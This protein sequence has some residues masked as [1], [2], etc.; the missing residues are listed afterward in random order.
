MDTIYWDRLTILGIKTWD[1]KARPGIA[2]NFRAHAD[3]TGSHIYFFDSGR[4]PLYPAFL[5]T[6]T[7]TIASAC[8]NKKTLKKII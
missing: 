3:S 1:N 6:T 4:I 5:H 2:N 7:G 8:S